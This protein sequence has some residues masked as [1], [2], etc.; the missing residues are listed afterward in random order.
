MNNEPSSGHYGR[1]LSSEDSH[2]IAPSD[3]TL[4]G[5][6]DM[7]VDKYE[8]ASCVSSHVPYATDD[9]RVELESMIG[10]MNSSFVSEKTLIGE[11]DGDD[12]ESISGLSSVQSFSM[13][14]DG[15]MRMNFGRGNNNNGNC[16]EDH[17]R[18]DNGDWRNRMD[19][20]NRNARLDPCNDSRSSNSN[21]G[22]SNFLLHGRHHS[23]YVGNVSPFTGDHHRGTY[24]AMAANIQ[25]AYGGEPDN[26]SLGPPS[27]PVSVATIHRR[28]AN[29]RTPI[30][31]AH[32]H[33]DK[34]ESDTVVSMH[35][36]NSLP[37]PHSYAAPQSNLLKYRLSLARK[38][39]L[40]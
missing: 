11:D 18:N 16:T 10:S 27:L 19:W 29:P 13:Y 24:S 31:D 3:V 15:R 21:G 32:Q 7:H 2:S 40:V 6:L 38:R 28:L 9:F 30:F 34:A 12:V 39:D 26:S 37:R 36:N 23:M 20:S 22:R 14:D 17:F 35:R 25:S 1:G 8:T 5:E 33:V 4:E